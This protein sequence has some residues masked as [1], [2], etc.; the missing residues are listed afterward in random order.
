MVSW[1]FIRGLLWS[2]FEG[3]FGESSWLLGAIDMAQIRN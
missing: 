1:S 2:G 3:G